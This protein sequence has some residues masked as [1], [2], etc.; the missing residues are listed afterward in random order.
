MFKA[1]TLQIYS[2]FTVLAMTVVTA[3]LKKTIIM[4]ILFICFMLTILQ[5]FCVK[6]ISHLC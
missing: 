6:D 4:T 3:I 2:E 1:E 5:M